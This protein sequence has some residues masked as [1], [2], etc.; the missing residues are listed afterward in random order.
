MCGER[1][2]YREGVEKGMGGERGGYI[3]LIESA[4][5]NTE[6]KL[7]G[8]SYKAHPHQSRSLWGLKYCCAMHLAHKQQHKQQW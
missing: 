7:L 4:M 3:I 1:D 6:T 5:Q 8:C 2:G